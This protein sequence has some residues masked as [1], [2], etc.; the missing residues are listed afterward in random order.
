MTNI[1]T[2]GITAT[3]KYQLFLHNLNTAAIVWL[4]FIK[5]KIMRTRHDNT[6]F[7]DKI[8]LIYYI[9]EITVNVSKI[10]C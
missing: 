8:M 7:L 5:K 4:V 1:S 9:M 3:E 10:I 6:I 2:W